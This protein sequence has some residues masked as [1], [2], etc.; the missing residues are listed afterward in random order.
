[1][2]N[3]FKIRL[4]ILALRAILEHQVAKLTTFANLEF[5]HIFD[6]NFAETQP[7]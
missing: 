7:I 2:Q 4:P 1:M 6:Y 5:H 3:I